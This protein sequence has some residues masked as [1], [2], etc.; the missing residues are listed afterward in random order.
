MTEHVIHEHHDDHGHDPAHDHGSMHD[1]HDNS[2]EAIRKEIRRYLI[3][4][5]CLGVLTLVTVAISQLKLPTWEAITLGLTVATIKGTL[6][7]AFFMHLVSER[8]LIY[9]VLLFTVFFFG[10]LL[11]GPWHHNYDAEREWPGHNETNVTS[12]AAPAADE[13]AHH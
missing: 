8:K 2:P 5:G 9:A 13:H 1:G 4:L 6:V 10:M 3:V 11:W 12:T 7:A